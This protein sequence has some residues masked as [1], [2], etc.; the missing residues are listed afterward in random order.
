MRSAVDEERLLDLLL[1]WEELRARGREIS[2]DE[3]C[4]EW[5]SLEPELR[6][7]L[8]ALEQ[9]AWLDE[10]IEDKEA[11]PGRAT[12]ITLAV[13]GEICLTNSLSFQLL[14]G[15]YRLDELIAEG[16]AARVWK[17]TDL[18]LQRTVAVKMPRYLG[19]AAADRIIEEAQRVAG[20]SHPGIVPTYDVGRHG[21]TVFFVSEFIDGGSLADV[22][23][24][25]S[26]TRGQ[27][28]CWITQVADALAYAHDQG[29]VHRDITP[30]NILIDAHGRARLADFGISQ[31]PQTESRSLG[32]LTYASPEQVGGTAVDRRSDLYSLGVVLHECVA[33]FLPEQPGKPTAL[34]LDGPSTKPPS[35]P[36][37]PA[38]KALLAVCRRALAADPDKR[39]QT[40]VA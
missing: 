6:R 23:R 31:P 3:L 27:L 4:R 24:S 39:F 19:S 38:G 14:A 12:D 22:C 29:V 17:A 21:E 32:T 15:R 5:P 16:G 11:T 40:A 8:E 25:G 7:R 10:P 33:G 36:G 26:P 35:V 18:Q 13:A 2:V 1:R 9:T 28:I 37:E 20:L 34:R 30:A